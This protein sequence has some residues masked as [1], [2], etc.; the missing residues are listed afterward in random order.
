[1]TQQL[2]L[3]LTEAQQRVAGPGATFHLLAPS[4]SE[5][6]AAEAASMPTL[7]LVVAALLGP[8]PRGQATAPTASS[9]PITHSQPQLTQVHH[10]LD[11]PD[12]F[13]ELDALPTAAL[14]AHALL[15]AWRATCASGELAPYRVEV[16]RRPTFDAFMFDARLRRI[17]GADALCGIIFSADHPLNVRLSANS[18]GAVATASEGGP[19]DAT[20]AILLQPGDA[21]TLVDPSSGDAVVVVRDPQSQHY[22]WCEAPWSWPQAKAALA[23]APL[24]PDW[25][26]QTLANPT[27]VHPPGDAIAWLGAHLRHAP[28]DRALDPFQARRAWADW[29]AQHV[30]SAAQL[31]AEAHTTQALAELE[32]LLDRLLPPTHVLEAE[33]AAGLDHATPSPW[34]DHPTSP[35]FVTQLRDAAALRERIGH[36]MQIGGPLADPAHALPRVDRKLD[37]A[38]AQLA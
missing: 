1:M 24:D 29:R 6:A 25:L 34:H 20:L 10:E 21:V 38:H 33:D 15:G 8:L 5:P 12:A 35:A 11:A 13:D 7:A 16:L 4:A 27:E 14:H 3:T 19:P 18:Q 2:T 30:T 31:L 17:E 32:A 23:D 9:H 22:A 26:A 37:R 28:R 36:L